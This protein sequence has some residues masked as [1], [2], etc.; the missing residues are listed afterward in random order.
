MDRLAALEAEVRALREALDPQALRNAL[1]R[2][3]NPRGHA[4]ELHVQG[5]DGITL[6]DPLWKTIQFLG[7]VTSDPANKRWIVAGAPGGA[8]PPG[9]SPYAWWR[10]DA[11]ALA[12]GAAVASWGDSGTNGRTLV[13]ATGANQPLYIAGAYNSL[14]CVRFDGTND[15]LRTAAFAAAA[16]LTVTAVG[17]WR[18]LGGLEGTMVG[19]F[20]LTTSRLVCDP[21][22]GAVIAT[23]IPAGSRT[24]GVPGT[25]LHQYSMVCDTVGSLRVD[26][27]QAGATLDWSTAAWGGFTLGDNGASARPGAVDICEVWVTPVLSASDQL[28]LEDYLRVK[29]GTP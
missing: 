3:W 10:A 7:G 14:P 2:S 26:G 19:A 15:Y 11:L 20:A 25:A 1:E 24:D 13:Q 21:G 17:A 18:S 4:D 28:A 29:W 8:P 5:P 27:V 12:P 6:P 23:S 9:L 22:A 16:P